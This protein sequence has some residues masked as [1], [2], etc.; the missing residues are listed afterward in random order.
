METASS[1]FCFLFKNTN[2]ITHSVDNDTNSLY[3]CSVRFELIWVSFLLK[4]DN[5]S[6]FELWGR[7]CL[8]MSAG[9]LSFDKTQRLV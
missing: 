5:T 7:R 8:Q 2:I 9:A 1:F 4:F 6:G 3:I